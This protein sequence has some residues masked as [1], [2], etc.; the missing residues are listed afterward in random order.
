MF[1]TGWADGVASWSQDELRKG[2]GSWVTKNVY[3]CGF[4]FSGRWI[5]NWTRKEM[6]GLF[7]SWYLKANPLFLDE[8]EI[9][10]VAW[11]MPTI[12]RRSIRILNRDCQRS[13]L[14]KLQGAKLGLPEFGIVEMMPCHITIDRISSF[15]QFATGIW[16]FQTLALESSCTK[17]LAPGLRS[18]VPRCY[19]ISKWSFRLRECCRISTKFRCNIQKLSQRILKI[20]NHKFT[21]NLRTQSAGFT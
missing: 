3:L 21:N 12:A 13:E 1:P 11:L 4:V 2:R 10:G 9:I 6:S 19:S 16:N 14:S 8:Y 15:L 5:C 20:N 18:I 17:F 7:I